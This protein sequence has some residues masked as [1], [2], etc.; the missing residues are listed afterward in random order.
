[1][2]DVLLSLTIQWMYNLIILFL[3]SENYISLQNIYLIQEQ[4]GDTKGVF[5]S[6]NRRTDNNMVKRYRRKGQATIYKTYT[7]N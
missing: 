4:F 2:Y 5:R 7:S 3:I 1:M 6:R